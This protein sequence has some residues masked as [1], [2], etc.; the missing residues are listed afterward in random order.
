MNLTEIKT[1]QSVTSQSQLEAFLVD[2]WTIVGTEEFTEGDEPP[3][4]KTSYVVGHTNRV[5]ALPE[6]I[7]II[8]HALAEANKRR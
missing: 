6:S 8:Y 1:T 3:L 5:Q 4:K 2:G 7:R